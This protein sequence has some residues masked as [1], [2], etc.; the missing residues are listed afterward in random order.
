VKKVNLKRCGLSLMAVAIVLVSLLSEVPV[1]AANQVMT[2]DLSNNTGALKYGASSFLYGLADDSVPTNAV[3][4][5]LK[6][7]VAATKPQGGL[8]IMLHP[9]DPTLN[10]KVTTQ[11]QTDKLR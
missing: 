6:P 3:L 11:Y 2:V 1:Y 5:P 4:L 8:V 9:A 7:R 10:R